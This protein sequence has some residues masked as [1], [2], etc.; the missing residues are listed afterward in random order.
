MVL[1]R[2]FL[3]GLIPASG[4]FRHRIVGADARDA[5]V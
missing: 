2:I 3:G 4:A 1:G 5:P